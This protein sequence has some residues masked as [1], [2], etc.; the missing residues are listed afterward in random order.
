MV[1]LLHAYIYGLE[2]D[3]RGVNAVRLVNLSSCVRSVQL[4]SF[5]VR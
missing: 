2:Q 1:G 4:V 5:Y 3:G